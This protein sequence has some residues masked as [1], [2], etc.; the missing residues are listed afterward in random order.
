MSD[1][2]NMRVIKLSID[3]FPNINS[4][5]TYF[6]SKLKEKDPVGRFN[7]TKGK[8]ASEG[9]R[10][11]FNGEMLLFTWNTNL[12]RIARA[13]SSLISDSISELTETG[14]P[15]QYP[16]FFLIDMDSVRKPIE[17]LSQSDLN[18]IIQEKT[19]KKINT[20]GQ[21]WN[22]VNDSDELEDWFEDI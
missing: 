5:N 6:D 16:N 19:G 8:I 17:P 12:V 20:I 18:R 15:Q 3:E 4:L 14:N 2:P 9:K 22:W 1:E 13:A 7:L 21:A 11:I 10:A